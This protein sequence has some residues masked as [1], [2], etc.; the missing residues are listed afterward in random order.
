MTNAKDIAEW[1]V[2]TIKREKLV[3][4][5]HLVGDIAK[6]FGKDWDSFNEA[7][8]PAVNPKILRQFRALHGGAIEWDRSD[9]SWSYIGK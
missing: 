9:K 1:M 7:G 3:Y 2:E 6:T 8:N 4:Q 5:E